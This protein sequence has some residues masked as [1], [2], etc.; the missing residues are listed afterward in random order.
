VIEILAVVLFLYG[1]AVTFL[2]IRW[3]NLALRS[4]ELTNTAAQGWKEC[5]EMLDIMMKAMA[6]QIASQKERL[7]D[8]IASDEF[9]QGPVN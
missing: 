4:L 1:L 2:A 8:F 3:R 7:T 6:D 5:R 9:P